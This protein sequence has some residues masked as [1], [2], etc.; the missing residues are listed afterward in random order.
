MDA[1]KV[2]KVDIHFGGIQALLQL[3]LTLKVG[4]KRA[5]IGPN[6][7]GKTTL[8][9]VISGMLTPSNGRVFLFGQNITNCPRHLRA[10]LGLAR[11]FQITNLFSTLSVLE[12][13]VLGIQGLLRT[14]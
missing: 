14:K 4:E 8:F 10:A 13:I 11:T 3:T 12:N 1:L 5:V 7:A 6:G 9:N 2:D